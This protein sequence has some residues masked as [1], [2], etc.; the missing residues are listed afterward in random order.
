M[1]GRDGAPLE[2]NLVRKDAMRRPDYT[3][4]GKLQVLGLTLT[5]LPQDGGKGDAGAPPRSSAAA[6][7]GGSASTGGPCSTCP[8]SSRSAR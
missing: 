5:A 1:R 6:A 4:S 7:M 3:N 8:S 2:R